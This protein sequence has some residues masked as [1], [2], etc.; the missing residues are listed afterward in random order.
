MR[1]IAQRAICLFLDYRLLRAYERPRW[2]S[3]L[4]ALAIHVRPLRPLLDRLIAAAFLVFALFSP[5]SADIINT[6]PIPSTLNGWLPKIANGLSTTVVSV[7]TALG[8]LGSYH[9]LNQSSAA[10]YVQIFDAASA[11]AVTLGSTTPTLSFGIPAATG[12]PGGGNLEWSNGIHFAK[13][14]QVAATTTATGNTAPS[15]ALD[16]NFTYK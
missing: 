7:K 12:F 8:E 9:C 16:C 3:A 6:T 1:K 11:G 14:I 15:P 5:A 4:G 10:A 13:G 2:R